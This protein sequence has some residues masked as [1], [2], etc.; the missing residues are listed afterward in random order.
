MHFIQR[1]LGDGN[2][3]RV[4]GQTP[5]VVIQI[6]ECLLR[7][8]RMLN[9]GRLLQGNENIDQGDRAEWNQCHK[10]NDDSYTS[11]EVRLFKVERKNKNTLLPIIRDNVSAIS[12]VLSDEWAPYRSIGGEND[13]I[14][15]ESVNHSAAFT[16]IDGVHTQNIERVWSSLNNPIL[17]SMKNTSKELLESH[18]HE[19]MWRSRSN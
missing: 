6:D 13:G 10:N 17:R 5:N 18:L 3:T 15:H 16:S 7:G 9:R 1:K 12:M 8:Q 14:L 11:G 4:D 19:F 2:G